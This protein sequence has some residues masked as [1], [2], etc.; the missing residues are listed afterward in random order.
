MPEPTIRPLERLAE[1]EA[2][3]ELQQQAWGFTDREVVPAIFLWSAHRRGIPT[4]GAFDPQGRL[5]G[6][7]FGFLTWHDGELCLHSQRLAVD[8]AWRGRGLARRLKAAQGAWALERGIG[9]VTWTYAPLLIPNARLNLTALGGTVRTY[10]RD[11]YGPHT[12]P[13]YGDLPSDRFLIEWRPGT[14]RV[15]RRLAGLRPPSLDRLGARLPW[16]LL[17]AP[18]GGAPGP[19]R[20]IDAPALLVSLPADGQRDPAAPAWLARYRELFPD[21]FARGYRVVDLLRDRE[22]RAAYLVVR[23]CGPSS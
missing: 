17:P 20:R 19:V 3:E 10:V 21:L 5:I 13:L 16:A 18:R 7:L 9:L 15:R 8:P 22:G 12:T 2:A 11:F 4:W 1:F 14:A 23:A 6:L